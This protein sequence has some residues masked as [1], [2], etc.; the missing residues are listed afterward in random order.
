MTAADADGIGN[1]SRLCLLAAAAMYWFSMALAPCFPGTA[2]CDPEFKDA[3]RRPR[4]LS[5][6]QL[7]SYGLCGLLSAAVVLA[8]F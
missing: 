6:Q 8:I 3:S 5:L 2:W 4:G 1:S 7:L